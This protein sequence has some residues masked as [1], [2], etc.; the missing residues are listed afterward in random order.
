MPRRISRNRPLPVYPPE[1][2]TSLFGPPIP[3]PLIGCVLLVEASAP[4]PLQAFE[5]LTAAG[6]DIVRAPTVEK[7][8]FV[9]K[10]VLIDAV[11]ICLGPRKRSMP[12]IR[13]GLDVLPQLPRDHRVAVA[14]VYDGQ[15]NPDEH[16]LALGSDAFVAE[17]SALRRAA[18]R[19]HFAAHLA[20]DKRV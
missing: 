3:P 7:A 15:L 20:L 8:C 9:L 18:P 2:G 17:L 12:S 1:Y 16:K 11:V 14:I 5:A 4:L 13:A 19:S 10:S 6:F